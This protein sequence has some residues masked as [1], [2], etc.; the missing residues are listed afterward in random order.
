MHVNIFH[1]SSVTSVKISCEPVLTSM[2]QIEY[3]TDDGPHVLQFKKNRDTAPSFGFTL[4]ATGNVSGSEK[5]TFVM[6][7]YINVDK[8]IFI[9]KI[10]N[11]NI[12]FILI[13][14]LHEGVK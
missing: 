12:L 2:F 14:R 1:Y 4:Q 10:E 13:Q 6:D 5:S 8:N 11:V 9:I 7:N 3:T